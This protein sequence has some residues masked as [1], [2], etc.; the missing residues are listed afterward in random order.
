[1]QELSATSVEDEDEM[2]LRITPQ[3]VQT[4]IIPLRKYYENL[5]A[6][7]NYPKPFDAPSI[8][9]ESG[10]NPTDAK[11]RAGDGWRYYCAHDLLKACE[12]SLQTN[13]DIIV[14]FD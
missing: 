9:D 4:L 12:I 1:M 7:L 13:E 11:W 8:D 5:G 3:L 6:K 2:M 10:L 14:S